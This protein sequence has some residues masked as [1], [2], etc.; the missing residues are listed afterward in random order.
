MEALFNKDC[1][2]VGWVKDN[3]YIFDVN[4]SWIAFIENGS[5]FSAK[6]TSWLGNVDGYN[7]LDRSG[8]VVTWNPK[9]KVKG[10]IPVIAPITPTRPVEPVTPVQSVTTIMTIEPTEPIG[11]WSSLS[12][13][14]WINQ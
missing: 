14:S 3:K 6:N 9:C 13:D 8:K 7:C 12:F 4:M 2:L 10:S 11:G 5:A 1:K